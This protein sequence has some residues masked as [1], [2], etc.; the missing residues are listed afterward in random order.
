MRV[1]PWV[2]GSV[3]VAHEDARG[4]YAVSIGYDVVSGARDD[5]AGPDKGTILLVMGLST[6]CIFWPDEF[7]GA[8]V[9]NGYDVVRFDNRDIGRSGS[10]DRG[11]TVNITRDF[12]VSRGGVIKEANYTLNDMVTDTRALLDHLRLDRVHVVGISMGGIIAQMLAA[13]HPERVHTLSLI[14]SHTN[15]RLWGVPHPRVLLSMGPPPP[16]ASR[17]A[18]I[19]RQVRTFQDLLG[20]PGHRRSDAELRHAFSVAYD[21]DHRVD[22]MERQTH[23]LFATPCIDPLLP[24]ITAPTTVLHGL[25]DKLVLPINSKRIAARIPGAKLTL[26][27]GMGHDFQPGLL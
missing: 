21:R 3:D 12:I 17:D 26:F 19:E 27:P 20:S 24:R 6:Q 15:H 18:V 16:G 14:M 9:D 1:L 11:V 23:A 13:R 22:G 7:V 25:A 8:F 4:S 2:S 5:D 10:V